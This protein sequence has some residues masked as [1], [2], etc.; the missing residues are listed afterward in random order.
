MNYMFF[1]LMGIAMLAVLASLFIGL[2]AMGR[3]GED[4]KR[5]SQKMMRWRVYLQGIALLLFA[6]AALTTPQ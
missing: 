6:L 2:F 4:A 1:V 3:E 5:L